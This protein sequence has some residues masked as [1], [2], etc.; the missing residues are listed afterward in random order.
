MSITEKLQQTNR[1]EL[2]HPVN[3]GEMVAGRV[4]SLETVGNIFGGES[5]RLEIADE[6]TKKT[7]AVLCN[8]WMSSDLAEKG[9]K[10]GDELGIRFDGKK[11]SKKS[12]KEY[13]AYTVVHEPT[14]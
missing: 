6:T 2:W 10:V 5:T 11:T 7:L 13:N 3:A 14:A 1:G 12:G 8:A 4:L 9:V